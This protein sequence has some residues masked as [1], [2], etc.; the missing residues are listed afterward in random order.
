MKV[1]RSAK[2]F[3]FLAVRRYIQTDPY[4]VRLLTSVKPPELRAVR[5]IV[6]WLIHWTE[7]RWNKYRIPVTCPGTKAQKTN[8]CRLIYAKHKE[9]ESGIRYPLTTKY[10]KLY[11][12][13]WLQFLFDEFRAWASAP[14]VVRVSTKI[15]INGF[16]GPLG[17]STTLRDSDCRSQSFVLF[18]RVRVPRT[19]LL[20]N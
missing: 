16:C 3:S 12:I 6:W 14:R 5:N 17:L 2:S 15:S 4:V 9:A 18:C 7:S 10:P 11:S 13:I 19:G 20:S 1:E 8:D